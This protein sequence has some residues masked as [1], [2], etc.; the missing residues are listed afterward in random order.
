M[1]TAS[2][3]SDDSSSS[4]SYASTAVNPLDTK[5][6]GDATGNAG[7]LLD[8]ASLVK[9]NTVG[10]GPCEP[11]TNILLEGIVWNETSNGRSC[12]SV[13]LLRKIEGHG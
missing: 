6:D 7:V 4:S 2:T 1:S 10:G 5:S 12:F 11:G 13:V 8:P 9:G 3:K